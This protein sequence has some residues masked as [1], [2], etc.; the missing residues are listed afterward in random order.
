MRYIDRLI[1]FI[2]LLNCISCWPPPDNVPTHYI[3]DE[4]KEYVVF[5]KGSYWVYEEVSTKEIDSVY[6]YRS[7]TSIRNGASKLGYN[8]EEYLSGYTRSYFNDSVRGFGYPEFNN[9]E[10]YQYTE[11]S[12]LSFLNRPII[13]MDGGAVG[14]EFNYA[15]DFAIEYEQH[16]ETL[17]TADQD[18]ENVKV[19]KHNVQYFQD[20]SQRIYFSK[21]VGIVIR[22][23]FNGEVWTL[24]RYHINH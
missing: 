20:Q 4:F 1:S 11:G 2:L 8:Y 14:F 5:P 17:S 15:E 22:E 7:E 13:F 9:Q 23:M 19:F 3:G 21:N 12:L 24:K 18:F 16:F 6:L 10:F